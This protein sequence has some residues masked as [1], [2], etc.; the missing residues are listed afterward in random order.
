[1]T[2]TDTG[3]GA[4]SRRDFIKTTTTAGAALMATGNYA[5][6]QGTG[7]L[8]VAL[9]GCGGRGTGAAAQALNADP[10]C[11][12]TAMGDVFKD[13]IDSSIANLK[14]ESVGSK[15]RNKDAESQPGSLDGSFDS[16]SPPR[17]E[18]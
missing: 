3:G 12:L 7:K 18:D 2:K 5:F 15:V 17:S 10:G 8:R 1:M 13:H 4:S 6:A 9:I 16:P 14:A 11:V